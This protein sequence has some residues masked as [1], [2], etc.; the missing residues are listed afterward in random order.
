LKEWDD[1]FVLAADTHVLVSYRNDPVRL[2]NEGVLI[3]YI[4]TDGR[5]TV[6]QLVNYLGRESANFVS[7]GMPPRGRNPRIRT[8]DAPEPK[9]ME[10]FRESGRQEVH[11]PPFRVF[12]AI[13]FEG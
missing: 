1:P 10:V 2:F 9:P 13:E 6:V 7:L 8:L 12:A 3:P 4:T 5:R 11:L